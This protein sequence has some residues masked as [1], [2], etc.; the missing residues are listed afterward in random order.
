MTERIAFLG[1]GLM[2]APMAQNLLQAGFPLAA[3]NRD[4]VKAAALKSAGA[5]LAATPADASRD[6]DI[7]ITMLANGPAVE[8][9][10]FGDQGAVTALRPGALVMDMS[11]S[12]P[13]MARDHAKRLAGPQRGYRALVAE[14]DRL[15]RRSIG[16]HGDD[17]IGV[18]RG[19][20]RG[21]GQDGTG[22]F[23]RRG[24]DQIPIPGGEGEAR[25]E[26]ILRHWRSHQTDAEEGDAFGHLICSFKDLKRR[27]GTAFRA[28]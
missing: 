25:L 17:D 3:W 26:Q 22:G 1:I 16:Q 18:A 23:Q 4:L 6:A 9:V 21:C 10:M 15:H 2:G 24:L 13:A 8:T 11:P 28:S 19:I 27:Q 5:V 14:H 7:V 12:P 20:R